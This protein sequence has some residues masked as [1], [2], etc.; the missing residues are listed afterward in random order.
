ML[1]GPV[2]LFLAQQKQHAKFS[3]IGLDR[4]LTSIIISPKNV[5]GHNSMCMWAE[6]KRKYI[7]GSFSLQGSL[8]QM[9]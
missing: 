4:F 7:L 5:N 2:A 3:Q 8:L 6:H 1:P 9:E